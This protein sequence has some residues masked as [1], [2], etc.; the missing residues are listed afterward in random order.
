MD[1]DQFSAMKRAADEKRE[2]ELERIR[3][4][5]ARREALVTRAIQTNRVRVDVETL[6]QEQDP[7]A[8]R[9]NFERGLDSLLRA[10]PEPTEEELMAMLDE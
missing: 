1:A 5:S 3:E 6:S 8:V 7:S 10:Q 4:R 9:R 2:R